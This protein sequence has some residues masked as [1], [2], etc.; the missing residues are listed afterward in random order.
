MF[1]NL[2]ALKEIIKDAQNDTMKLNT[3]LSKYRNIKRI[4][5]LFFLPEDVKDTL[6]DKRVIRI[7]TPQSI[8]EDVIKIYKDNNIQIYEPYFRTVELIQ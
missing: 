8:L 6:G 2:I 5:G 3:F 4:H 7:Y 1:V